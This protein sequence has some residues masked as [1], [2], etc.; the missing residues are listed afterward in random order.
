MVQPGLC[1]HERCAARDGGDGS[2]RRL[3]QGFASAK[4][5]QGEEWWC[6]YPRESS[7]K[8]LQARKVVRA[9]SSRRLSK[10]FT[11]T[12]TDKI[13]PGVLLEATEY[14]FLFLAQPPLD[15]GRSM[16]VG[17]SIQM[18][19]TSLSGGGGSAHRSVL[20]GSVVTSPTAERDACEN[21][22]YQGGGDD[23]RPAILGLPE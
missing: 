2:S 5:W 9:V 14:P 4:T 3:S 22:Q 11:S 15:G 7:A 12:E 10:G 13:L 21:G 6:Q 16:M 8:A 1:H 18:S 19:R 20:R 23:E 17:S